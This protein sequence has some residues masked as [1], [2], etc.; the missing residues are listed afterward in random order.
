MPG[1]DALPEPIRIRRG[2]EKP[3]GSRCRRERRQTAD[4]AVGTEVRRF[5][6]VLARVLDGKADRVQDASVKIR[7]ACVMS[8][9]P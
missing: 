5:A 7:C 9:S 3:G 1:R 4:G 2:V 6:G 8:G